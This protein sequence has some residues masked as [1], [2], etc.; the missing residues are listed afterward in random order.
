[1]VISDLEKAWKALS[2][3]GYGMSISMG[4]V[5]S[6]HRE[7]VVQLRHAQDADHYEA[8]GETLEDAISNALESE[9]LTIQD[10]LDW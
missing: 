8:R 4:E 6:G 3:Q 1:M 5:Y 9:D 7:F 2:E 10:L